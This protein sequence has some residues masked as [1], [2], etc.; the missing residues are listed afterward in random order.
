MKSLKLFAAFAL[1]VFLANISFAKLGIEL[2]GGYFESPNSFEKN[3]KNAFSDY[4]AAPSFTTTNSWMKFG[5][6]LSY[7]FDKFQSKN[8]VIGIKSGY[9]NYGKDTLEMKKNKAQD[10]P[11][12]FYR[13]ELSYDLDS[14][15]IPINFYYK[16][17]LNSKLKFY[18]GH[19][20]NVIFSELSGEGEFISID[21]GNAYK[22]KDTGT[23]SYTYV[24]AT[25]STGA[26]YF[27]MESLSILFD[28]SYLVRGKTGYVEDTFYR[29]LSGI[30]ASLSLKAYLF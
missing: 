29:D 6:L 20:I 15:A 11:L 23:K 8:V 5:V 12:Y 9:I 22:D 4:I 1:V 3:R 14:Y 28:V 7:E 10:S 24:A 21:G 17:S 25:F 26:E 2:T 27:L 16:Y 30:S 18:V 13:E 19:G